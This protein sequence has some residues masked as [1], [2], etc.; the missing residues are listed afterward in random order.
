[1]VPTSPDLDSA[2]KKRIRIACDTCRRKKIKCNGQLPCANCIQVGEA[3]CHYEERPVKKKTT[4]DNKKSL[5]LNGSSRELH[6]INS[7]LAGLEGVLTTL[8][9]RL[10]TL[11]GIKPNSQKIDFTPGASYANDETD[12]EDNEN[13]NENDEDDDDDDSSADDNVH[14]KVE[15]N[16]HSVP[17]EPKEHA[18]AKSILHSKSVEQY[19]GTHSIMCIFSNKS[20]DW[21]EQTLGPEGY[22]L[23]LPIKNIPLAFIEKL[24]KYL[25]KWIDPPLVDHKGRKRLIE[26]PFPADSKIVFDFLDTYYFDIPMITLAAE[27]HTI[28]H[29][30]EEY[31]KKFDPETK[32]KRKFKYSEYLMMTTAL[33]ICI[34]TKLDQ[35]VTE[36]SLACNVSK[37]KK[38]DP[39]SAVN[40]IS[41][42][43]LL[44]LQNTFFD[45]AIYYYHR[46]SVMR[47][48]LETIGAILLLVIFIEGNFLTSHV[49]YTLIAVAVRYAQEMGIH[50]AE[51]L[52]NLSFDEQERRRK[53]WWLCQ[54]YDME[55][56][57]RSGKPPLINIADVTTNSTEDFKTL[58]QLWAKHGVN[59]ECSEMLGGVDLGTN[60]HLAAVSK[61]DDPHLFYYIYLLL[62]TKLRSKSYHWLFLANAQNDSYETLAHKLNSLNE[63]MYEMG[64]SMREEERP[65][66]YNDPGFRLM[67]SDMSIARR[68]TVLSVQLS[69]FLHLMLM[70]RLAFIVGT[71]GFDKVR[72]QSN[73]FRNI[74]LN[75][76][77]TILILVRQ[78]NRKN[79][80][81]SYFKW[82]IFY[83]VCAFLNISAALLNHPDSPESYN[84][85]QLLIDSSMNFFGASTNWFI[86]ER[87]HPDLYSQKDAILMLLI[88]LILRIVIRSYEIKM[89]VDIVGNYEGLREHIDEVKT[90]FPIV[91]Q[92]HVSAEKPSMVLGASPF[93]SRNLAV[94]PGSRS[95]PGSTGST[96]QSPSF[97]PSLSNILHPTQDVGNSSGQLNGTG[98]QP[99]ASQNGPY[100]AGSV[101]GVPANSWAYPYSHTSNST[102]KSINPL[103]QMNQSTW[104]GTSN[105]NAFAGQ[106]D[107]NG[108]VRH[109][110]GSN[111]STASN[112]SNPDIY[113]DYLNDDALTLIFFSQMDTLPNFFF[114]NNLGVQQ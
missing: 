38:L 22:S 25:L 44:Q 107:S 58:A 40:S 86:L 16:G 63:E 13:D 26:S 108:R 72:E 102:P 2:S 73:Q 39:N 76:A 97:N 81:A 70:N 23:T 89:N 41:Y 24:K 83:P 32:V 88:K 19:F 55:I 12:D 35:D 71:D 48:G 1:M 53:L 28:R 14:I 34:S 18:Q 101:E 49:N 37:D 21:I 45:N 56:C 90:A 105:G 103:Q 110:S 84:D 62:L 7:R 77:R 6:L 64:A 5:R 69:Y 51:T 3:N 17:K 15:K 59:P 80:A 74:S 98:E 4:G 30:F 47:D 10:D 112:G 52:E 61:L 29:L 36:E 8:M 43:A 11:A 27:G 79:T 33:M 95:D 99:N 94:T 82:I 57:F 85:L 68:E 91:F 66:F 60:I 96:A 114:D 109:P 87:D 100:H 46:I 31:Y 42:S 9:S 78:I 92:E 111:T 106:E 65:R 104:N 113:G 50:R 93:S 20:L 75:A 54:Y 67:S